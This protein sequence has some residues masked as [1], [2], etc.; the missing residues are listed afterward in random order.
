MQTSGAGRGVLG[1]V[2]ALLA[3]AIVWGAALT[4]RLSL[5]PSPSAIRLT[6]EPGDGAVTLKW[7]AEGPAD[8][9]AGWKYQKR[10]RGRPYGGWRKL[11]ESRTVRGLT[12]GSTYVFRVR[13]FN[14]HGDGA[15]SNAVT[16]VPGSASGAE[17]AKAGAIADHLQRIEGRLADMPDRS[18]GP[19]VVA[20]LGEIR[21]RLPSS[22]GLEAVLI[23]VSDVLTSIDGKLGGRP[24]PPGLQVNRPI[25]PVHLRVHFENAEVDLG[26]GQLTDRGVSLTSMQTSMLQRTMTALDACA[27]EDRPVRIKPYGFASSAAFS[28]MSNSDELNLAAANRRAAAVHDALTGMAAATGNV[29]LRIEAPAAWESFAEMQRARN[30]CATASPDGR[31]SFPGRVVVL[32][33]EEQGACALTGGA[34]VMPR[35]R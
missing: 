30:V 24:V 10:R 33:L 11:A 23:A 17:P 9:V 19:A 29:N 32:Q 6:A 5:P 27:A 34:N 31:D 4:V 26:T 28:G 35:C 16:A 14:G 22:T 1:I 18:T 2:T 15:P 7:A 12:N 25:L 21:D 8:D 13:A 3:L 20:A